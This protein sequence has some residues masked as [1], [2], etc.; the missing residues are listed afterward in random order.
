M[1]GGKPSLA[2]VYQAVQALYHDPDPAGK[3]RASVWLGELQRSMYAWE[4]S[5]Q[6][7]QLKQ[8]VESCYFAAQTMKMKIQTSFYELPADTHMSLRDSLLAHIENLKDLSPII[9]TQLALAIADLALQ[10]ASWKGCVHTH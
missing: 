10:M 7:L 1:E 3:E 9:V 8:D 5:D 4:I 2:L 6:L